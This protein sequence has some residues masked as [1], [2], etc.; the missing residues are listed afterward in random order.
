MKN[1]IKRIFDYVFSVIGLILSSPLWVIIIFLIFLDE[2]RPIFY[3]QDR[4]GKNG[5]IFKGIKFRSMVKTGE[6][7]VGFIQAQEKDIR[8]TKI[9]EILRATAMDELPQ[10]WNII[11]GEMSFVGPRA[12][13]PREKQADE[14]IARSVFDIPGFNE[15]SKIKPGL[16]GV[17]Q[18]FAPRDINREDKFRYDIWYMKNQSLFLD[19]YLLIL[20][21]LVTFKGG[22]EVRSD[23]FNALGSTLKR[24]IESQLS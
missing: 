4:V 8:V 3:F 12:L 24:R 21:F 7:A 13:V 10:L 2:G 14:A 17:A 23:K 1:W 6:T 16:T 5:I 9:G 22:W 15:R 20:S 11:K 19:L 18:V